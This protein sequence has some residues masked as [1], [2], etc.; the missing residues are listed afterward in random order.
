MW[1]QFRTDD[2]EGMLAE[3]VT[4]AGHNGDLIS[5][6]LSRPLGKGPFPAIVLVAHVPGWDEFYRETSRRF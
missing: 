6:Y 3:T 1:N 4:M 2:Y 5:A